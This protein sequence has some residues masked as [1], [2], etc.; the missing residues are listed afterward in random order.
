MPNSNLNNGY[1]LGIESANYAHISL[2]GVAK[3]RFT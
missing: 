3:I 2:V 1:L